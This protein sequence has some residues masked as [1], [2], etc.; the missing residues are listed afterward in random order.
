MIPFLENYT[1]LHALL[2]FLMFTP[3]ACAAA[4]QLSQRR[5]FNDRLQ[6]WGQKHHRA[7]LHDV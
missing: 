6:V 4:L 5:F 3:Y 1:Y 2:I 7:S